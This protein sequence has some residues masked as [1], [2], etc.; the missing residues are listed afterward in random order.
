MFKSFRQLRLP[1]AAIVIASISLAHAAAAQQWQSSSGPMGGKTTVYSPEEL[2]EVSITE[3]AGDTIPL[4]ATFTDEGGKTVQLRQYFAAKRPV[5]LQL[6]YFGCPAMCGLVSHGMLDA[7]K[8]VTLMPA[9]D[10]EILYVSIDPSEKPEL[11]AQKK[12]SYL[13][14]FNRPGAVDG[15]HFLTGKPDQ[16]MRLTQAVGYN[17]RWVQSAQQFAHPAGLIFLTPE[18]K[19]ARYLGGVKFDPKTVRLSL[20]ESSDGKIGSVIDQLFLT[21]FQFDGHQGRYAF[22]AIWL[23]R[24]GGIA[25]I[26]VVATVLTRLFLKERRQLAAEQR[27]G[28]P[29]LAAS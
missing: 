4:D 13:A 22:T 8:D 6:G 20:V 12:E 18:G 9:K 10:F 27:N 21:C 28:Q 1:V 25:V 2:K 17:F 26:I 15:W 3:H 23:M 14:Q 24:S 29:P 11:A 7:L 5:I 16:I 19:I